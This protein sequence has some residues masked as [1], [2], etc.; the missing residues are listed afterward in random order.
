M[1]YLKFAIFSKLFTDEFKKSSTYLKA[2]LVLKKVFK[3]ENSKMKSQIIDNFSFQVDLK[4]N[5]KADVIR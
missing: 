5:Y 1:I 4:V 3:E 2:M